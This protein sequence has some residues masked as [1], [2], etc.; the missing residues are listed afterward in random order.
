MDGVGE[1][2]GGGDIGDWFGEKWMV[3]GMQVRVR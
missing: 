1:S 3:I 2:I